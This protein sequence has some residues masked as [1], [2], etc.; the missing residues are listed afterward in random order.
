MRND[1]PKVHTCISCKCIWR[2]CCVIQWSNRISSRRNT[3]TNHR[4]TWEYARPNIRHCLE[5][6]W[7]LWRNT[8]GPRPIIGKGVREG[9]SVSSRSVSIYSYIYKYIWSLNGGDGRLAH[10]S[11]IDFIAGRTTTNEELEEML[12]Q[13]NPAVFT[14]GVSFVQLS[15]RFS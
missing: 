15:E 2:V 9:Y 11:S 14:Q 7:R 10:S 3:R 12:E 4:R 8:I 13:G 5:N 6:L 1:F